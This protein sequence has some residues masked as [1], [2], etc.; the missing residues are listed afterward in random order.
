MR[1]KVFYRVLS[2]EQLLELW[3]RQGVEKRFDALLNDKLGREEMQA[4]KD[5][6]F[7]HLYPSEFGGR[8]RE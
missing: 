8:M 2:D 5:V 4:L 6:F 7:Q 3:M 1:Q